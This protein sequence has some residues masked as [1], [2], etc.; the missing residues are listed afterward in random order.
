[1]LTFF[2]RLNTHRVCGVGV[3]TAFLAMLM[4]GF[5][6]IVSAWVA[7]HYPWLEHFMTPFIE[8]GIQASY[9]ALPPAVVAAAL[10]K[11]ITVPNHAVA[12]SPAQTQPVAPAVVST[13]SASADVPAH[14]ENPDMASALDA[15]IKPLAAIGVAAMKSYIDANETAWN[16][17]VEK[18]AVALQP[19]V[20][21]KIKAVVPKNGI[22]ANVESPIVDKAIEAGAAA[23]VAGLPA[24]LSW[25]ESEVDSELASIEASLTAAS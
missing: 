22:L 19:V 16:A 14:E 4:I 9:A 5:G 18:S 7:V 17:D 6:P 23:I 10:G 8:Y 1:M 25:A 2:M 21:A 12:G 20:V 3:V 11:P 15:A 24:D 13:H